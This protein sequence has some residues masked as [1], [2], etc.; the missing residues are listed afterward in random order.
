M[1]GA[2]ATGTQLL[3]LAGIALGTL[4]ATG[5]L[6]AQSGPTNVRT[7][8]GFQNHISGG[9]GGSTFYPS[10]ALPPPVFNPSD[11]YTVPQPPEKPVSPASPGSVFGDH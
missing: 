11:P 7:G 9:F 4:V 3:V 8:A 6:A 10:P 5:V 2:K 1:I